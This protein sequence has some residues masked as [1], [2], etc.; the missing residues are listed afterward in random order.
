MAASCGTSVNLCAVRFTRL[1]PVTGALSPG[2][3]NSFVTTALAS[4]GFDPEVDEGDSRVQRSAC[5]CVTVQ[6]KAEDILL[7]WNLELNLQQLAPG[8]EEMLTGGALITDNAVPANPIGANFALP[9][10]CGTQAPAVA[11]EAWTKA[12]LNDAQVAATPYIRWFWPYT[13]WRKAA[14]TLEADF[15]TPQYVG[16]TRTNTNFSLQAVYGDVP[17][18]AVITAGGGWWFDSQLP[19]TASCDYKTASST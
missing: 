6:M 2:P 3:N 5:D 16:F 9:L 7:R 13:K 18:G 4:L 12:W 11:I 17:A 1:N 10:A 14:G 19:P 15:Q 8:L